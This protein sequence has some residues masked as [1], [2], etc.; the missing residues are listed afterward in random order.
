M[1][2]EEIEKYSEAIDHLLNEYDAFYIGNKYGDCGEF[3]KDFELL[4]T[5]QGKKVLNAL[6]WIKDCYDCFYKDEMD[7]NSPFAYLR[8]LLNITHK[9]GTNDAE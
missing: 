4:S 3:K 7:E 1:T 2:K 5:L 8:G 6:N 9:G